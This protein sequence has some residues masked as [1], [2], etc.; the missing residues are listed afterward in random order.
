MNGRYLVAAL[1]FLLAAPACAKPVLACA[2]QAEMPPFTYAERV[3][4]RKT[5]RI[6]G[7]SVDLL[8]LVGSQHGWE[9]TV[10][11]LPWARCLAW[12]A[13][14]RAQFALNIGQAEAQ[15]GGLRLSA[16]YF[17]L[18]NL[19]FY[20]RG[21]HPHGLELATLADLRHYHLCG[22]G[23]YRFEPF[24]ID[25][26]DVDR[27]ATAGY[28]QLIAKLHVG[29]CDLFIDSRETI[30]GMYLINPRLRSMLVDGKL[31]NRPLPGSPQRA[32]HFAVSA[33]AAP[34]LLEQLDQGLERLAK[35]RQLDKLLNQ[36]LD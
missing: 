29:R 30:A 33:K 32:L 1:L 25:T 3:G 7:V 28:E 26:R 23:G 5:E 14:N 34:A 21:A 12:V 15:A 16:P 22:L 4:G 36:Y 11:L 13:E 9:V 8:K 31:V 24:G 18:H 27:G 19:Y 10:I 20:S 17:T 2:D 35:N 6:T